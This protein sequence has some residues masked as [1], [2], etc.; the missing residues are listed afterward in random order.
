MKIKDENIVG[1]YTFKIVFVILLAFPKIVN[2]QYAIKIGMT[3]SNFY[4]TGQVLPYNDYD[5]DLRPY[6]GYDIELAQTRPQAALLSPYISIYRTFHLA[7]RLGI[8]PELSYTQ[9]GVRFNQYDYER[10]LYRVKISYLELPLSI[11]YQYFQKGNSSGDIFLGV[12]GAYRLGA[13]KKVSSHE[14]SYKQNVSSVKTLE[15]GIHAG[16]NYK[17]KFFN[18]FLLFD[19]RLFLGLSDIFT[20]PADWTAIY[21]ETQKTKNTGFNFSVGYEF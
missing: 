10:I 6:L 17:R 16:I 11:A 8:R 21:Y 18:H 7:P 5:I 1:T 12:F 15:G 2:A 4:Y 19:V 14:V 3:A 20:L 13:V 9:K